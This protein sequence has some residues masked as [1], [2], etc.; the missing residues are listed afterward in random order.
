[1]FKLNFDIPKSEDKIQLTDAIYLMGSCFSDEIGL[2]LED[3]KFNSLSN[4]FGTI[5]NPVSLFKLLRNGAQ[6]DNL[7]ENQ[8]VFYHWDAHGSISGL[9]SKEVGDSFKKQAELSSEY[10]KQSN[11]LI[12]TLGTAI[13]YE[14]NDGSIVAN[15][16][17]VPSSSFKKRFLKQDEITAEFNHLHSYLTEAK[18]EL[19]VIFTISP[20][21]HI[22]DGLKENNRSKS[23]LIDAVHEIVETH[24]SVSYF[25]SYE[26]VMDE[27]RDYRFFK[28]DMI[29]P[30]DEAIHY[31]WKRFI[32]TYFNDESKVFLED[33][34]KL[35]A[36]IK[37]RPFQPQSNAHQQ[38]LKKTLN[39]LEKLNEK[40]NMSVEIEQ[41]KGQLL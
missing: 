11:W 23:I 2:L 30:S 13:V 12:I 39:K 29:H 25:P 6:P 34:E 31:V 8:G 21:R 19:N 14:L 20:V 10:L 32:D 7:V 15:C 17:K 18:P 26:I 27:L 38:F 41:L 24:K 22:R 9:S 4:P 35:K 28:S 40:V 5:Y 36:A 1:M 16:H 37:H 3:N 33:W